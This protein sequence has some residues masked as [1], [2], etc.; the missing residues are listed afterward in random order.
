AGEARRDAGRHGNGGRQ[1]YCAG[2]PAAA[3]VLTGCR[4]SEIL[5]LRWEWVDFERACL[6]LP[7][8]KTGAR[9][10]PL[11]V[12]ALQ[13]LARLPRVD[14][15][16]FVLPPERG[17]GGHFVGLQKFWTRAR[18]RAGLSD[19]RL[20]DFQHSFAS[21]AVADGAA[22]YLVGKVL[23]HKQSRTTEIYAHL[24]DDPLRAVAERTAAK[25]AA[26]M[27]GSN[28]GAEVVPLHGNTGA[29]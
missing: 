15:R 26:A 10:I 21:F 7:D 18:A 2:C 27:K 16:S 24:H 6:R 4:K 5:T 28:G 8:S 25:I 23:G 9:L 14:R 1:R 12:P 13:I 17:A 29:A 22:L 3:N 19:V 20:H 11:G